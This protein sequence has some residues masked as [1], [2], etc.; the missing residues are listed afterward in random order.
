M[1]VAKLTDEL[2]RAKVEYED[3]EVE[4]YLPRLST[5]ADFTLNSI[6]NQMG[7]WDIFDPQLA[8]LSKISKHSPYLSRIIHKAQIEITEEGTIASAA[9]GGTFAN[10]NTPPRFYA[11]R[12]FA[13][14]ILEKQ[15][16]IL[17]FCGQVKDPTKVKF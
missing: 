14:L 13:Y 12:P 8:N 10:K 16:N 11:N 17:I 9:S 15:T 5:T 7:L 3:D 2:N 6:L 1:G 4:V